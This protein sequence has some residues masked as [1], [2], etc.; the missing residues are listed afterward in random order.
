MK[1][2]EI[3]FFCDKGELPKVSISHDTCTPWPI[4]VR[5]NELGTHCEHPCITL[6]MQ[7]EEDLWE[8]ADSLVDAYE[9]F[10]EAK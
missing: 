10:K 6:Y 2:Y 9:K 5:I 8:F 3:S 1:F 7:S 4:T